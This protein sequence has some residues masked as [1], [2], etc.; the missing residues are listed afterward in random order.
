MATEWNNA[1]ISDVNGWLVDSYKA[2][3]DDWS[4]VASLLD[5]MPNEKPFFLELRT[6][7]PSDYQDHFERAA[8]FIY[9]NKTCFRGLFRVNKK[10]YFNVPYGEYNRRYY[11]PGNLER[12]G[13]LLSEV[14]ILG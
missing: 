13:G 10:G 12:V 9:L 4:R 14:D 2:I 7:H 3:R 11:D 6:K 1:V 5:K 8:A